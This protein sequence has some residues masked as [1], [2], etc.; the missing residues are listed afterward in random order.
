MGIIDLDSAVAALYASILLVSVRR[1]FAWH[2][3]ILAPQTFSAVAYLVLLPPIIFHAAYTMKTNE[4]CQVRLTN[5][6]PL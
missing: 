1:Y 2:V 4:F 5:S 6:L 3:P